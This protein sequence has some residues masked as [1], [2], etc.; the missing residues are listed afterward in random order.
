MQRRW[1]FVCF[2]AVSIAALLF[3]QR[4]THN[5]RTSKNKLATDEVE[6]YGQ[7]VKSR[8]F[9]RFGQLSQQLSANSSEY[10]LNSGEILFY[11]AEL[12]G[13]DSDQQRWVVAAGQ[14]T[15]D[16]SDVVVLK[17]QVIIR[18]ESTANGSADKASEPSLMGLVLTTEQL[19][20]QRKT[21]QADTD[22]PVNIRNQHVNIDATGMHFDIGQQIITLKN[23]VTTRYEAD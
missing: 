10:R 16:D 9:D 13:L 17:D 4:D 1:W 15:V 12:V 5:D 14:A 6:H 22:L 8:N 18:Q 7:G 11:Q 21:H 3:V 19:N 20:Y 23:N 2:L